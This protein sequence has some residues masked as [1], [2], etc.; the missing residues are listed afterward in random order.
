MCHALY[1]WSS[2]PKSSDAA[3]PMSDRGRYLGNFGF[4]GASALC[5]NSAKKAGLD[6]G[7]RWAA[8]VRRAPPATGPLTEVL[9]GNG[10]WYHVT[11]DGNFGELVFKDKAAILS[12][13]VQ[14][15]PGRDEFGARITNNM[16]V[17]LPPKC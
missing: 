16:N 11:P 4:F 9:T 6:R 13:D 12:D 8:L 2:L 3:Q 17:D 7:N 14:V 1:V 10:P 15:T 5:A